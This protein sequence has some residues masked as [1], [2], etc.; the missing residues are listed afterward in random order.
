MKWRKQ[1]V[2]LRF[3]LGEKIL[4]RWSLSV[5]V[6]Q[7]FP[8]EQVDPGSPPV[9]A[10]N[11]L[12]GDDEDG[13]LIRSHP[14]PA[15]LPLFSRVPGWIRYV[16]SQYHRQ[17]VDLTQDYE[18]YLASFSSKSRATLRRKVRRYAREAGGE[19]IWREYPVAGEMT[20]FFEKARKIS[21][22]T[23]QDRH[24]GVGLPKTAKFRD[25]LFQ[26]AQQDG[27]RCYLLFFRDEPIAY[28]HC[29]H[30]QGV[31]SY[32]HLGYLPEYA[33]LS[34]GTV[35]QWL[36]MEKLFSDGR[37]R[38]FDFSEGQGP[39]KSLFSS[40]SQLC[41][42]VFFLPATWRNWLLLGCHF[43]LERG[44]ARVV[45]LLNRLGIKSWVKRWLRR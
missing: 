31:L 13:V 4:G 17:F 14:L 9:P 32:E 44:S 36:V 30:Q 42:N 1:T 3:C 7:G 2:V 8:M 19:I 41:A 37:Y 28:L 18:S 38:L 6:A 25:Q 21:A 33:R 15:P 22:Q 45:S 16:S 11:F 40:G 27:V 26:A 12:D 24:L 34:P 39:Q 10:A 35:L 23:Y 43:S 20:E 29:P 5:R